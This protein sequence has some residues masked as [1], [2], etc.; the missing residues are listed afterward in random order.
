MTSRAA[1]SS[2]PNLRRNVRDFR[3]VVVAGGG[4]AGSAAALALRRERPDL[5]VTVIEASRFEG[6]RAGETLAP[7][8]R[9][10]LEGLGCWAHVRDAC[11]R[12][13][14]GTRAVWGSA[15]PYDNEFLFSTRGSAW[16]LDRRAFDAALLAAASD[17]GA[18][19]RLGTRLAGGS[20]APDG[21]W[22]LTIV[23]DGV[24]AALDARCVIDAT[25]RGAHFASRQGARRVFADRLV[26]L[27]LTWE[28]GT[29]LDDATTMVEACADGWWYSAALPNHRAV[30]CWMSDADLVRAQ[31]LRDPACMLAH[32]GA[33]R[34]TGARVRD[35]VPCLPVRAR[36]ARSQQLLP[37]TGE[38]WVAAGDAAAAFDPLSSAG[39]V[40][41]LHS[42]KL[43]AYTALDMVRG[44][45]QGRKKYERH[46]AREYAEYLATRRHFYA[47]E[48]RWPDAPFWARRT[49]VA[50]AVEI[51][52]A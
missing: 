2:P 34:F 24:A 21:T 35:A 15:E 16:Q 22:R 30:T 18:G 33:T 4:P 48:R 40:K 10:I 38:G 47:D 6:W 28:T 26:G 23:R 50:A 8:G 39:I 25:G 29:D 14:Y 52:V 49:G 37:V 27:S 20:R 43:A 31:N 41:A 19:V 42:G 5:H 51:G 32:L 1:S 12:E 46:A 11:V 3:D 45:E 17:A 13:S 44:D 7:G 36:S 9:A